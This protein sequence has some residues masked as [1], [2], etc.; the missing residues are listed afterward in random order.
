[1]LLLSLAVCLSLPKYQEVGQLQ[2]VRGEADQYKKFFFALFKCYRMLRMVRTI[3]KKKKNPW[4]RWC[5]KSMSKTVKNVTFE[6][7]GVQ[8]VVVNLFSALL[9]ASESYCESLS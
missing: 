2:I 9:T 7:A 6:S 3:K 4:P 5:E 1:L 8:S